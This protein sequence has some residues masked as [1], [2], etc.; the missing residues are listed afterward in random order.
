MGFL[1]NFKISLVAGSFRKSSDRFRIGKCSYAQIDFG[2][3]LQ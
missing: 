3:G 1:W 2:N